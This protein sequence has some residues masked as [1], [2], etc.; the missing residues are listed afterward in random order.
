M[1]AEMKQAI[2]SFLALLAIGLTVGAAAD[3]GAETI[4]KAELPGVVNYS[5]LSN[6]TGFAGTRAG[7]GGATKPAAMAALKEEGYA[8]VINLRLADEK[9]VDLE[10]SR[11][12]AEAAGMRYIHLPFESENPDPAV[13]AAFM[14][15][16]S[17][18]SNQPVYAHCGSA[19]RVGALWMIGRVL[20]DGWEV[21][22]AEAEARTIAKKP[23]EAVAIATE[24][25]AA[26]S[27]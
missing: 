21:E 5:R 23:E 17:D 7:F 11:A 16:L 8:T 6:S 27:D 15:A 2:I 10:A 20:E 26:Q 4:A 19:T 14:E 1:A 12:A 9:G 13:V 18:P 3:G 25:L 24:Y 22:T